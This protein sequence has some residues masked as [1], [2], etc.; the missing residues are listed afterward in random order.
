MLLTIVAGALFISKKKRLAF[1]L[2][3][4]ITVYLCVFIYYCCPTTTAKQ[5]IP[6]L[7]NFSIFKLKFYKFFII[8]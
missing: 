3:F 7:I 5:N 1:V 2:A 8:N 6:L 4:R